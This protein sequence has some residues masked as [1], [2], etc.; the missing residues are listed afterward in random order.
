MDVIR[1]LGRV[2]E[3]TVPTL[4]KEIVRN[5]RKPMAFEGLIFLTDDVKE[6]MLQRIKEDN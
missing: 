5:S 1:D 3:F 6:D 2:Q 4:I